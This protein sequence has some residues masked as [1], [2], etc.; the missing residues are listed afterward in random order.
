[1]MLGEFSIMAPPVAFAVVFAAVCVLTWGLSRLA[2][3]G[4]SSPHAGDPYSCG[5]QLPSHMI[6]PDYGQFLPFAVFFTIL[7]VMAL[8]ATTVPVASTGAFVMA[9]V[10]MMCAMVGLYVI[11]A[12]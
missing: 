3:R 11:Y 2:Y 6:Q 10:Y 12:R 1:M 7:H 9:V 4:E 5:E 8:V